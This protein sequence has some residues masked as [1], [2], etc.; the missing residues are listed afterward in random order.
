MRIRSQP[1]PSRKH[2]RTK[3]RKDAAVQCER[4]RWLACLAQLGERYRVVVAGSVFGAEYRELLARARIVF[5]RSI[6]GECS[7]RVREAVAARALLIQE[8]DN[9]EVGLYPRDQQQ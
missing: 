8:D 9:R 6:C 7:Q 5:N 2:K 4:L 3:I 1:I